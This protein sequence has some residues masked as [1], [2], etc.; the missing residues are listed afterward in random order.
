MNL[1]VEQVVSNVG[2][3]FENIVL[4]LIVIGSLIFFAQDFKLGALLLFVTSGL[5]FMWFFYA[6]Y[7]WA[8]PLVV[9]FLSLIILAFSLYAVSKNQRQGAII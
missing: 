7:A 6:G 1:G 3:G 4:L 9:M 2:L 8:N 5:C